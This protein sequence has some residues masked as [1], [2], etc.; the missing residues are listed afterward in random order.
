[1]FIFRNQLAGPSIIK[2]LDIINHAT[3]KEVDL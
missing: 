2:K 1:M 3:A